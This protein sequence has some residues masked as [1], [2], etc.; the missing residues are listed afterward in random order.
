MPF[1]NITST[2]IS[3]DVTYVNNAY[4]D[5]DGKNKLTT[6]GAQRPSGYLYVLKDAKDP[7]VRRLGFAVQTDGK[8][9]YKFIDTGSGSKQYN[10]IQEFA[11]DVGIMG[12]Y[13]SNTTKIIKDNVQSKL[14]Q[15]AELA[16]V[17][18]DSP[19]PADAG[20]ADPGGGGGGAP[21]PATPT[22]QSVDSSDLT[23]DERKTAITDASIDAIQISDSNLVR[24][25]YANY[26]YPSDLNSEKNKQDRIK[27][28]MKRNDGSSINA[29]FGSERTVER[30]ST[31][32]LNGSVTLPIQPSISDSNSVDWN[33]ATLNPI[34]AYAAGASLKLESDKDM[35]KAAGDILGNISKELKTNSGTY[36]NAMKVFFAQEAVGIQGLLSRASGAILNPNLELLFNGPSLR[37]F[38]FTFKMSPRDSDEATHVRNII[39][40]FKQGMSVKTS[41]SDVFVKSPNIFDIRYITYNKSGN[42]IDHPSIG[43]IKT[44]ALIG[45]DVDYAPDSTYMTFDDDSRTMT[46]YQLT[47]RFSE[48]EPVYEKDFFDAKLSTQTSGTSDIG[49]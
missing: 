28:T 41:S 7:F 37:P 35:S 43:R 11:N 10:S 4:K 45:C 17:K 1:W 34:Q 27:F 46:S 30:R 49:F 32:T 13:T 42:E 39:R 47:L 9:T 22:D 19:A 3:N 2:T 36:T 26:Y 5:A 16:G 8:I 18:P 23:S 21:K 31:T 29:K 33:G 24:T 12:G 15:L 44:C 14:L 40:F 6:I 38:A 20:A 25:S 48:L